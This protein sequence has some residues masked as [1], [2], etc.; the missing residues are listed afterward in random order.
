MTA[1]VD[2]TVVE[3]VF[4]G[5]DECSDQARARAALNEALLA[6]RAPTH[7]GPRPH[8]AAAT[9]GTWTVTMSVARSAAGARSAEASIVDDAGNVVAHR[10]LSDRSG[11]ACLPLAH[12]V[13]AWASL[14]LDAEMN[15]ARD[16]LPAAPPPPAPRADRDADHVDG[17]VGAAPPMR[18]VEVGTMVYL[19]DG[20]ATTGGMAGLSPFLTI[21][22]VPSWVLRPALFFGRSTGRVASAG[23]AAVLSHFGARAD[24]CRRIPGNYIERRGIEAD[25][26]GAIDGGVVTPGVGLARVP[27]RLGTGPS[28]DLRGELGAGLAL[29]VRALVGANLVQF[30]GAATPLVFADAEL[31]LSMRLP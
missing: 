28:V 24:I 13:G 12:A 29:E 31:G 19:R 26:C 18:T 10:T 16:E 3:A 25:L 15:R 8:G 20:L 23:D 5:G 7:G 22:L 4:E 27:V 11:R 17:P 6:A 14:V 21:E 1:I 30:A 2:A 9:T